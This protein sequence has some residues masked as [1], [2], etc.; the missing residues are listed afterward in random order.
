MLTSTS[1]LEPLVAPALNE[2]PIEPPAPR[3]SCVSDPIAAGA[4]CGGTL[5]TVANCA[6]D[7]DA[8]PSCQQ[9]IAKVANAKGHGNVRREFMGANG[10]RK[11][12]EKSARLFYHPTGELPP[13]SRRYRT[14]ST[15]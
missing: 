1:L 3:L 8:A 4:A 14:S 10:E 12:W 15:K 2:F 6:C 13:F 9:S 7:H 11:D 5:I